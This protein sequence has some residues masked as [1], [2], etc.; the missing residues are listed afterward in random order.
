MRQS[1]RVPAHLCTEIL[2]DELRRTKKKGHG[3]HPAAT[4]ENDNN[5]SDRLDPT[6]GKDPLEFGLHNILVK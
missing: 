5:F 2:T 1:G 6:I 4:D 3:R